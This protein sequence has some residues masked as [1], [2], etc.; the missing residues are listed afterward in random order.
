MDD[1]QW[2]ETLYAQ[3]AQ[4]LLAMGRCMLTGDA[5]AATDVVQDVFLLAWE[6]RAEL[7]EHPNAGG[8]LMQALKYRMRGLGNKSR[9]RRAH[10]AFSLDEKPALEW[11]GKEMPPERLLMMEA[12]MDALR[13]VLGEENAKL[14]LAYAV[15]GLSVRELT[16]RTGLTESGVY[17]RLRRMKHRLMGRSDLFSAALVLLA[18][19]GKRGG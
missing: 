7:R 17:R 11:A 9:R 5:D 14:F 6:R 10:L 18:L 15:E 12:R 2:F 3:H 16:A 1:A 8:W 19:A 13:D 4:A